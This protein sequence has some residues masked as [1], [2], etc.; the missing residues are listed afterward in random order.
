MKLYKIKAIILALII[1]LMGVGC[2]KDFEELNKDPFNPTQTSP[3]F[4]F[5][6]LIASMRF[7]QNEYLYL[8]NWSMSQWSQIGASLQPEN[9]LHDF[10]KDV[11][12]NNYFNNM[13]NIRALE[14]QLDDY[15]GDQERTKNQRALL[16]IVHAY[17][18]FRVTDLYGD[19]PYSEA[20]RGAEDGN[21]IFRPK[22]D[23]QDDIYKTALDDLKW[24]A[25]NIVTDP[26]ATTPA[27]ES[28]FNY[29]KNETLFANDMLRWKKLA[30]ALRLRYALRMSNVDAAGA[31]AIISDVLGGNQPLPESDDDMLVFGP[32]FQ[33]EN[34]GGWYWSFQF[35]A[36]IRMGE[37]VWNHMTEDPNP[38]GSGI[39]DPRVYVYFEPNI[40]TLWVPAPQSPFGANWDGFPYNDL[41][42]KDPTGFEHRGTY[43]GY[44]WF[45]VE[46]IEHATE[47]HVTYAEV[48]FLR[49]EAYQRGLAAGNAQEWYENGIRASIDRWYTYG[50]THI[51]W[52]NPPA[53]PTDEEIDAYITHPKVAYN[54]GEGL[55]LIHTQRWLDL[56]LNPQEANHLVRRSGLIPQLE[57]KDEV[58]GAVLESPRRLTYPPDEYNNNLENVQSHA[59]KIGG[60]EHDTRMWWDVN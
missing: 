35:Y 56:F 36:N 14:A 45:L 19:M 34:I 38:D 60:D 43:S 31:N 46:N 50:T 44:N 8:N 5:N 53:M 1:M 49:A 32:D 58:S 22:Y 24:A 15:P 37:N 10:A 20:G 17:K 51:E 57:V 9:E 29:D 6:G 4:L 39:I 54:A 30:N 28:Y 27:G 55:K 25:D 59:A 21:Q 7:A 42:R 16:K 33:G 23:T 47:F 26:G 13:R 3:S 12:W 52:S 40:D 41:R 11:V 2:D 48:C 18:T